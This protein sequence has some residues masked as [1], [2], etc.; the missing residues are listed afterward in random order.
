L[1]WRSP[2]L[3]EIQECLVSFDNPGDD[4]NNSELKLAGSV[5]Q[6]NVLAQ[7]FDV[8]EATIH[9]SSDNVATVWWQQKYAISSSG[10]TT[11]LLR[12]E[13]LC[14]LNSRSP[15]RARAQ[16]HRHVRAL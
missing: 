4:I 11:R 5:A 12:L 6:H 8:R 10:P 16:T 7:Q 2:F 15:N 1:L 13:A 9:D 3:V 14:L